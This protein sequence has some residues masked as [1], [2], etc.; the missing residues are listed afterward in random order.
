MYGA[1]SLTFA[2]AIAIAISLGV[3][4]SFAKSEPIPIHLAECIALSERVTDR[5]PDATLPVAVPATS[6]PRWT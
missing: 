6:L 5:D 2:V 1:V 4:E 3:A